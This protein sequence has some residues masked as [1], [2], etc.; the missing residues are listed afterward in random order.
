METLAAYWN[1]VAEWWAG[2][3]EIPDLG[4]PAPGDPDLLLVIATVLLGLG[5]T[6]TVSA[7]IERRRSWIGVFVTL[8]AVA[9]FLWVWEADREGFGWVRVPEAFVEMIARMLN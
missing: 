6:V 8:L 2:L 4:L 3:P 9:M 1:A 5:L 7:W